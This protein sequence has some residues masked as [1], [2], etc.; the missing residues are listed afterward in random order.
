MARVRPLQSTFNHQMVSFLSFNDMVQLAAD[1]FDCDTGQKNERKEG[2]NP[3]ISLRSKSNGWQMI[4]DKIIPWVDF[5]FHSTNVVQYL[6]ERQYFVNFKVC[7]R[8]NIP[9]KRGSRE[10]IIRIS[11]LPMSFHTNLKK[12]V[13][14]EFSII[15]TVT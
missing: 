1:G 15:F 3:Q 12:K 9:Y 14:K 5:T 10:I 4:R 11:D 8:Y 13:L 6:F 2:S 7:L